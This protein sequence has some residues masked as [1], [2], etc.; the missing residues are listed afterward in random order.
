MIWLWLP[1]HVYI[2]IG[3][4][5]PMIDALDADFKRSLPVGRRVQPLRRDGSAVKISQFVPECTWL[6]PI[7]TN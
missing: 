2:S 7:E 4:D 5:V 3:A 6:Q 1:S